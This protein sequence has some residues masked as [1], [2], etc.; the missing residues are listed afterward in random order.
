MEIAGSYRSSAQ[1]DLIERF[2]SL[3]SHSVAGLFPLV[4]NNTYCLLTVNLILESPNLAV[5]L[6]ESLWWTVKRA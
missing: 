1:E 6:G 3:Q 4:I 5:G 2:L